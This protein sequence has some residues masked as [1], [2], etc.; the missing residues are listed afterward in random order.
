MPFHTPLL[1]GTLRWLAATGLATALAIAPIAAR[2][3]MGL[4]VLAGTAGDGPV[5]VFYPTDAAEQP[6]TRGVF[7]FTL[8]VDAPPV[9]GNGRLVVISHGSGGAPWVHVDLARALVPRALWWPCPSTAPTTTRTTA[10][11]AL[12]AGSAAPA[13]VSRAIDALAASPQFGPLLAAGPRGRVW[14]LGRRPHRAFCGRRALV[15]GVVP[16]HCEAHI[17]EDFSSCVG[18]ITRLRGNWLDGLKKQVALGVLRQRFD[19]ETWYTHT[20]RASPPPWPP[21]RLPPTLTWPRSPAR[22]SRWA[23]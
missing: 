9:R 18:Y 15:A 19:D 14:R 6:V 16:P 23:W 2:A 22:A 10:S 7:G 20:T 1:H 5:T 21:C 8:A 13:E 12:R 17:A 3:G 4:A 11:P